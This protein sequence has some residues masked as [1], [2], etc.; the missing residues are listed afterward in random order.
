VTGSPTTADGHAGISFAGNSP[1]DANAVVL[2]G[3]RV[4]VVAVWMRHTVGRPN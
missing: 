3:D 4:Y 2:A 1:E